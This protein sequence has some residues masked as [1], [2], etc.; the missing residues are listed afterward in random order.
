MKSISVVNVMVELIAWNWSLIMLI[1]KPIT[2]FDEY[3]EN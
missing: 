2:I 1:R 3:C